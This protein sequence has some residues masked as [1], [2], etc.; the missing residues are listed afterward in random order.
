MLLQLF[1]KS[2]FIFFP[3]LFISRFSPTLSVAELHFVDKDHLVRFE[4]KV[5]G[6]L[7]IFIHTELT[8][9]YYETHN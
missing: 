9:L 3:L 7:I 8:F 1:V 6:E 2:A 4:H 5:G